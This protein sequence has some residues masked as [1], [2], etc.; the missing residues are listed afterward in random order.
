MPKITVRGGA[1]NRFESVPRVKFVEETV[2]PPVVEE[3]ESPSVGNNSST[4]DKKPQ[5]TTGKTETKSHQRV[6]TMGNPS[7]KVQPASSS[8]SS[9][10]GNTPA[11][12]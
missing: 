1:T 2:A 7:V 9:T 3:G 6:P 4:L 8:A 11:T 5:K 12:T 10:D